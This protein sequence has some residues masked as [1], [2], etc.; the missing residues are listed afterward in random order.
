MRAAVIGDTALAS[1]TSAR[2]SGTERATSTAAWGGT[3]DRIISASSRL[4]LRVKPAAA[5][6][7][8]RFLAPSSREPQHL[9]AALNEQSA[10]RRAHLTGVE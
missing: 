9:V 3:T 1:I 7:P 5:A 2:V 8:R 6:P 10:D 4:S